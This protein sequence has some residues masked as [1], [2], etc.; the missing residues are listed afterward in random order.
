[1]WRDD[2]SAYALEPGAAIGAADGAFE[3][4][5]ALASARRRV[6]DV[7]EALGKSF[8]PEPLPEVAREPCHVAPVW[9]SGP[10]QSKAFVDFQHDV[11]AAD[12]TLAVREGF[13][14][15]EHLKRYTTLG[16]ATDQGRVGQVNGHGLLAA[17][18]GRTL[19]ETGT[20]RARPPVVPVAIG[21]FAGHHRDADF[22]PTRHTASHDWARAQGRS[23][24]M[25][26]FG[27]ASSGIRRRAKPIGANRWTVR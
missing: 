24:W 18:T 4:S 5:A 9:A 13:T 26:A 17:T 12:V 1:M 10:C 6:R 16:M 14:S 22:R 21:A 7:V 3:L 19:A 23:S 11:T 15:V 2:I 25:R 20:I 8:A 27:N